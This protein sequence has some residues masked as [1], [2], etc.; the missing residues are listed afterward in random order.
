MTIKSFIYLL[1]TVGI[2]STLFV[3]T[4]KA[5]D[6][7]FSSEYNTLRFPLSL[8]YQGGITGD[9]GNYKKLTL[10]HGNAIVFETGTNTISYSNTRMI[11]NNTGNVGIG[12]INPLNKLDVNGT[13]HSKQVNI[14]L[15]G[16]ADYVFN[17]DYQLPS[18]KDIKAYINLNHHLPDMPSEQEVIKDGLN[19]GEMNKLLTKKVEELTLYLIEKDKQISEQ[20]KVN[21][22]FQQQLNY[23]MKQLKDPKATVKTDGSN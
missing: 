1:L 13:M 8:T 5:Q 16:W 14:D 22:S 17:K 2:F 23:L 19:L 10:F 6:I 3:C 15:N 12:T 7:N 20:Q 11:I 9:D 18:L 4:T 21:Q